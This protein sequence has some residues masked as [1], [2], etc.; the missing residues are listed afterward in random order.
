M[1]CWLNLVLQHTFNNRSELN[2]NICEDM[3]LESIM[4]VNKVVNLKKVNKTYPM[5]GE[6]QFFHLMIE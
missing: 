2:K 3:I 6:R 5:L 4:N 1:L